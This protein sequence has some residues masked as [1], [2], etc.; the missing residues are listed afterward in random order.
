[1]RRWRTCLAIVA[2]GLLPD[3]CGVA[4]ELIC[5]RM[6]MRGAGNYGAN[7]NED[8]RAFANTQVIF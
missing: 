6:A 5:T 1:M 7:Q 4:H 8:L 3:E 2:I